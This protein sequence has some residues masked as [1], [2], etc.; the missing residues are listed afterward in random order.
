[1]VAEGVRLVGGKVA[2]GVIM[3][4]V[5]GRMLI[6]AAL[7]LVSGIVLR[8]AWESFDEPAYAQDVLNCGRFDSQAAAQA[9]LKRDPTDPNGLDGLPGSAF[10]GVRG[11]AC[12][13]TEYPNPARDE[14]PV[15][16]GGPTGGTTGGPLEPTGGG[17]PIPGQGGPPGGLLESGGPENGP[18]PLMPDGGCPAEY[19]VERD[20]LCYR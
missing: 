18:V 15:L 19:P 12:E 13:E 10:E 11:V 6:L 16:P 5:L 3:P 2:G 7:V 20:N 4:R 17:G 1:M 8:V 9:V 14:T